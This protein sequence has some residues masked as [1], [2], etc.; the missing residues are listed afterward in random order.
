MNFIECHEKETN[1]RILVP[2]D[3]IITITQLSED[4]TAFIEMSFDAD[5]NGVGFST[6]ELYVEI[7]AKIRLKG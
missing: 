7:V 3:K 1:Q 4:L 6:K 5:G 2:I